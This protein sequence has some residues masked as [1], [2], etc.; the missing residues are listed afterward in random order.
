MD[1]FNSKRRGFRVEGF[2]ASRKSLG[3]V[4][5]SKQKGFRADFFIAE[6]V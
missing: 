1:G 6:W 3:Q 5:Y 2:I 4:I